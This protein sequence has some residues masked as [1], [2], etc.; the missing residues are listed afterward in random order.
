MGTMAMRQQ[1]QVLPRRTNG[2]W[3]G[4]M[5]PEEKIKSIALILLEIAKQLSFTQCWYIK[6]FEKHVISFLKVYDIFR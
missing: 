1:P 5:Q 3:L 2:A 6:G 4:E